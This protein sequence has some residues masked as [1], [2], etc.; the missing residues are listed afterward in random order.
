MVERR[1]S[2]LIDRYVWSVTRH[3]GADTGP[4]IARELRGS[5]QDTVDAKVEAGTDPARAEEEALTELG[6]PEVLARQYGELPGHLVGPALYPEY[7]RMLRALLAV[8]VPLALGLVL[9]EGLVSGTGG[10]GDIALE[11][12]GVLLGVTVHVA[13]WVTLVFAIVERTR[14]A[15]ERDR[16]LTAW[17]TDQLPAEAPWRQVRLAG[18][19]V[20]VFLIA[21]V[22]AVLVWQFAGVTDPA[23]QVQ[24]LDPGLAPS[25]KALL[26]GVLAAEIAV[27]VTVWRTGHWTPRLAAVNVLA[28][29]TWATA[30]VWLLLRDELI[31]PDL[32][33]R[34]GAVFGVPA[35]WSA[36]AAPLAAVVIAVAVWDAVDC[37]RRT[38]QAARRP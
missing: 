31:A 27:L 2:T 22:I 19:L 4:D 29:A 37:L 34:L 9:V 6:D 36:P 12:V 8:L 3:L 10:F 20:Q 25:W 17:R 13:F 14:P 23:T 16:P 26:V 28:G 15:A 30:A 5:L 21:L 1:D 35:D 7:V 11:A 18:T 24:V 38:R 33:E 32:P